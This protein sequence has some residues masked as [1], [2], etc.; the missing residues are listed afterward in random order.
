MT[1]KPTRGF[2]LIE[3]LVVI[4]II[5]ILASVVLGSLGNA[6]QRARISNFKSEAAGMQ[7]P[8]VIECDR[9]GATAASIDALTVN[10]SFTTYGASAGVSCGLTGNGTFSVTASA[11]AGTCTVTITEN[12]LGAFAGAD[13]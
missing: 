2:T 1:N 8:L 6:R 9:T 10:T 5:G 3:L 12:G 13:C 4:A 7:A 11:V